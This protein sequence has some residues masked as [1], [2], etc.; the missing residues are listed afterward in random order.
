MPSDLVVDEGSIKR[1]VWQILGEVDVWESDAIEDRGER[2]EG[3]QEGRE[4]GDEGA[5][6][7]QRDQI[8][9]QKRA[10]RH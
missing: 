10:T 4:E 2:P 3:G 9:V 6:Y 8:A 7:E 5:W 1:L